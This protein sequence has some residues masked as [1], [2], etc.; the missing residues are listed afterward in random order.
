[1]LA[2]ATLLQQ[3]AGGSG[4]TMP[5]L[6]VRPCKSLAAHR[7]NMMNIGGTGMV[8]FILAHQYTCP[9]TEH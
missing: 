7:I 6:A 9:F 1:M 4:N 8:L 2:E 5:K 3:Y